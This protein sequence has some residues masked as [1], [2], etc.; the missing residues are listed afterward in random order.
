MERPSKRKCFL[1]VTATKIFSDIF[2]LNM[3]MSVV[4]TKP[5]LDF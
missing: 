5:E 3:A 1:L 2:D 4:T